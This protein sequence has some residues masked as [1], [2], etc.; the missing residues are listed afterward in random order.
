MPSE[1]NSTY[2]ADDIQVLKG[3]DGVR[4]RPALYIG[5][6]GKKG[7]HHLIFEVLDNSVDEAMGGYA[8][9]IRVTLY[10][11]NSVE[12]HDNGRGIPIDEHP[13]F[14]KPA[15]EVIME[16]LHSGG[17]FDNK[18]YKISGG[19]HGVG[20]SVVNAL[21]EWM[22]VEVV[23]DGL[24]YKQRFSKGKKASDPEI[25]EV[26]TEKSFKKITFYPDS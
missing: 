19:L 26:E 17:K 2:D 9:E 4:K 7:L 16:H 20:L 6:T 15:L 10:K 21:A 25:T 22:D 11:N 14:K 8:D 3:L 13:E 24:C 1:K 23:R 5:S 12:I 18:S